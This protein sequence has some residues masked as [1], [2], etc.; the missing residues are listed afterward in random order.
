MFVDDSVACGFAFAE[1]M[2]ARGHSVA[3]TRDPAAAL[4]KAILVRPDVIVVDLSFPTADGVDLARKLL[5]NPCTQGIPVVAVSA[6]DEDAERKRAL[7]AGCAAY[8]AKPCSSDS[9]SAAV[10]SALAPR[11]RAPLASHAGAS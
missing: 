11:A 4:E 6:L 3:I 5:E 10:D 1:A 8:L 2:L 9:I 7:A